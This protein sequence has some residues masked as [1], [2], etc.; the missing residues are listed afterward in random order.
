[1]ASIPVICPNCN[2]ENVIKHGKSGE[3]KQ[4]YRCLN[5]EC[6]KNTFILDY[7]YQGCLA[8]TKETIIDMALN[9]SG[10]RDTARVLKIAPNTVASTILKKT[11]A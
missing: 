4:R 1:M 6:T 7:S 9:G 11:P 8:Q 10:I 3:G 2:S 5:S